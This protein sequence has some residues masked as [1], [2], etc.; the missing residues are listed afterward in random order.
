MNRFLPALAMLAIVLGGCVDD[1]DPP[2][3]LDHDRIIAVRSSPPR[4][5]AGATAEL[6]AL[7]GKLGAPPSEERPAA[8]MVVTPASLAPALANDAGRWIVTAPDEAGLAAARLELGLEAGA[9]VP[10]V[11]GVAFPAATWPSEGVVDGL[12]ATKTVWLGEA[13]ENPVLDSALVDGAAP[14]A[15]IVIDA[16]AETRISVAF[17][18]RDDINWLTSCGTM[19]DFDLPEAYLTV[20][21]EDPT[22]GHLALVVRTETGG[23]AWRV[24]PM[25]AE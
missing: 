1:V 16:E 15:E 11:V 5:V 2:W 4:I 22:E 6:D 10:L 20:E 19:H 24:W 7:I 3:Q 13:A 23:V 12:A 21:E 17:D 14:G 25:R 18:D 9:P 8:A